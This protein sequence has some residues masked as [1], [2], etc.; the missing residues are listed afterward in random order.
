M[1][2][3]PNLISLRAMEISG[4]TLDAILSALADQ[5]SSLADQQ[6]IVV[7]GGS[8]LT[9]LGFVKR[10]TKDVDIL[11]IAVNGDLRPAKPLPESLR[12]ARDRVTRDFDLDEN[13]LNGGPTDLL[14]WDSQ[15]VS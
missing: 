3:I 6:E 10:T 15:M 7:I 12:I 1:L 13:W 9:A 4:E 11:A 2:N 14:K 8:A 5:L